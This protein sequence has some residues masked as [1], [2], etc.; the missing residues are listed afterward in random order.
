MHCVRLLDCFLPCL[1]HIQYIKGIDNVI[2]TLIYLITN[3]AVCIL[4]YVTIKKLDSIKRFYSIQTGVCIVCLVCIDQAIK[5]I[6]SCLNI[7][8]II[9]NDIIGIHPIMNKE[10]MALLNFCKI[11]L[12]DAI[13]ILMKAVLIIVIVGVFLRIK[14]KNRNCLF[15]F[16]FL[17]SAGIATLLDSMI[18]GYTLDYIYFAGIT[19]Y[20][21]KDFYVDTAIGIIL[22]EQI[23]L[24][25]SIN[26]ND[27]NKKTAREITNEKN[28]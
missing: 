3:F 6:N 19:C 24:V 2:A 23:N 7:N 16:I 21:L 1:Y 11:D 8:V 27:K 22:I 26:A 12:P 25:Q 20:D 5:W 18:W 14:K 15:A 13:I 4:F 28:K 10:Q 17:L 9:W